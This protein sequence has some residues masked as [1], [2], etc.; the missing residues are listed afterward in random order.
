MCYSFLYHTL[1]IRK[2]GG[3]R[4][5]KAIIGGSGGGVKDTT[6]LLRLQDLSQYNLA[7]C[8]DGTPAAYY[9][10]QRQVSLYFCVL[11]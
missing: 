8:A 3:R 9:A 7:V 4:E 5:G 10:E 1:N 6:S 2:S 11:N